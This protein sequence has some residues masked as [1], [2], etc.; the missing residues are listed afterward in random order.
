MKKI[1][2][3][4]NLSREENVVEVA[5]GVMRFLFETVARIKFAQASIN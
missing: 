4:Q 1:A 5:Q 2:L 3:S